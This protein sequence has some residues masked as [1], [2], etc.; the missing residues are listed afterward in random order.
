[1]TL[2]T[3][4]LCYLVL[5]IAPALAQQGSVA[6]AYLKDG[7][8]FRGAVSNITNSRIE[9]KV[10]QATAG[11][12]SFRHDEVNYVE[13]SPSAEWNEAMNLFRRGNYREAAVRFEEIGKRRTRANF[14][15]TRGNFAT[16]A[17][18]R[19][20]DCYRQLMEPSSI[21][22]VR[23]RIEW[24]KLPPSEQGLEKV[25]EVWAAAGVQDW[26]TVISTADQVLSFMKEWGDTCPVVIVPTMYY[27]TPTQVFADAGVSLVIWAN[28]VLR[29]SI[30]A[31]QAA[32]AKIH[33]EQSLSGIQREIV[34]VKEI[35]R[36]QNAAELKEAEK[37]YLP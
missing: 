22:L 31:M 20:L 15:P 35:F 13:F 18:R 11:S 2:F 4:A 36:L 17:D 12:V 1:M 8:T 34:P 32:A 33:A 7:R 10:D 29:A 9:F 21:P 25:T 24:D 3:K 16:L 5:A 19:L 30:T 6:V 26:G 28:H 23:D 27:D 14:Y 37:L